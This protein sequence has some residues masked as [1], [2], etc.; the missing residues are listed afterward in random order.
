[1][2]NLFSD[3]TQIMISPLTFHDVQVFGLWSSSVHLPVSCR[4]FGKSGLLRFQQV[5]VDYK[6]RVERGLEPPVT[7]THA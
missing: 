7:G 5:E 2:I 1:M 6:E 4:N 3:L